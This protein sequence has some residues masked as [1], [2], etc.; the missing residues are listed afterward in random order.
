MTFLQAFPRLLA[1]YGVF[2]AAF[3]KGDVRSYDQA[4]ANSTF[5]KAL[6]GKG[7]YLAMERA[8]EGCLRTLF[9]RVWLA[10]D[11]STR[12]SLDML[13]RA[14]VWTGMQLD[15]EEAEWYVATLIH[16]VS[17]PR[18]EFPHV[19][20]ES[21]TLTQCYFGPFLQGYM[22]GYIS[23]ERQMVVLSAKDAFPPLSAVVAINE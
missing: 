23:H 21:V 15:V 8:R 10:K 18:R 12:L 22:K 5:E 4:L 13:H 6:I 3:R 11:R 16:K 19:Q 2:V 20:C 1:L 9:R 17:G 14:L 7:V